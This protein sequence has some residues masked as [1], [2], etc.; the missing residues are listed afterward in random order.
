MAAVTLL[1]LGNGAP[2]V[3]AS[4]VAVRGD[5]PRT[6]LGAILSGGAFVVGAVAV[7]AGPFLLNSVLFVRDVFFYLICASVLFYV[8][9]SAEIFLWQAAGFILFY[10]FFVGFVFWMDLAVEARRGKEGEV[11]LGLVAE[12]EE[13]PKKPS[14]HLDRESGEEMG[15]LAGVTA[16][17]GR[18]FDAVL[19]KYQIGTVRYIP[20]HPVHYGIAYH[21]RN[22]FYDHKSE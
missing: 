1:A 5:H 9:L 18:S 2:D 17:S 14:D 20:Y 19:G 15:D 3:F 6:D 12:E 4:V 10:S 22:T 11:E 13:A 21:E 8:Y 7:L 16:K